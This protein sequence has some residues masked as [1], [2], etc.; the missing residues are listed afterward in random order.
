M[1][2]WYQPDLVRA[3]GL[4]GCYWH[5]GIDYSSFTITVWNNI[6]L[7]IL[8]LFFPD[9]W[10]DMC[11]HTLSGHQEESWKGRLNTYF[12]NISLWILCDKIRI[13]VYKFINNL[14]TN[15][16][17]YFNSSHDRFTLYIFPHC[18]YHFELN[19]CT[20]SKG[21]LSHAAT[22]HWQKRWPLYC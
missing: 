21:H 15:V 8:F 16:I 5:T 20:F 12:K 1:V 18:T 19:L 22:I 9:N 17:F 2:S 13:L 11:H 3:M 7:F 10:F 4:D 6:I 14:W